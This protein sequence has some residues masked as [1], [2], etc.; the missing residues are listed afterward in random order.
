MKQF[1]IFKFIFQPVSKLDKLK[2]DEGADT[3]VLD[4]VVCIRSSYQVPLGFKGTVV[5]EYFEFYLINS[6]II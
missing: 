1:I 6:D 5:S 4:R 2:A 3:R